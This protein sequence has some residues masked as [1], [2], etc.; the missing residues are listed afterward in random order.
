[1][2]RKKLLR[3]QELASMEH[4]IEDSN[5]I[6]GRI[7]DD[8]FTNTGPLIVE[9]GCGKG[10]YTINLA[11]LYPENNYIGVDI[12]GARLWVG[13]KEAEAAKLDNVRFVKMYI[14]HLPE[15]F[16]EG[17]IDEIWI[18]FPDPFHNKGDAKKRLT[19][20][21]FQA[22]YKKVLR[23][24]GKIHLKTDARDLYAYTKEIIAELGHTLLEDTE[25]IYTDGQPMGAL[26]IQTDFEKRHLLAGRTISHLCWSL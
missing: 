12:K 2:G 21:K 1:M 6:Y 5:R 24:G 17:E 22:L 26:L 19:S 20:P 3:Y 18:T 4:I 25:D 11:K 8:I 14:D 7:R 9:L 15:Y 10:A 13:A 16:L 23:P